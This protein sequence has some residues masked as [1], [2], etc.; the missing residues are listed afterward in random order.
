[1][2]AQPAVR[3]C[4]TD[5]ISTRAPSRAPFTTLRRNHVGPANVLLCDSRHQDPSPPLSFKGSLSNVVYVSQ[6]KTAPNPKKVIQLRDSNWKDKICRI[7]LPNNKGENRSS[8]SN[9]NQEEQTY[10]ATLIGTNVV[11]CKTC[12]R[13]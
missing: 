12:H 10:R 5:T 2:L 4:P 8:L 9:H 6:K 11:H 3:G 13:L 7:I 1:M